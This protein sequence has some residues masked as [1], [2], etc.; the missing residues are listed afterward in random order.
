L[1]KNTESTFSVIDFGQFWKSNDCNWIYFTIQREA[2]CR[3]THA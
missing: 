3:N 1:A 2:L